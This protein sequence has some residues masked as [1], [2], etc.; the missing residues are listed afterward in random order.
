MQDVIF[1]GTELHQ[2]QSFASVAITFDNSDHAL[3]IDYRLEVTV[4]RRLYRSGESGI[5]D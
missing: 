2:P 4:T 5:P 3:D 1:A